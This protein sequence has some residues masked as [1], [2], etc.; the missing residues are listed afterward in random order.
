MGKE[1]TR[2][3]KYT[4]YDVIEKTETGYLSTGEQET[5]FEG[6]EYID[7]PSFVY[8]PVSTGEKKLRLGLREFV[9]AAVRYMTDKDPE[10]EHDC[11]RESE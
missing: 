9:L 11:E 8:V 1:I 5:R 10:I 7:A 3:V 6:V 4:V 2:T